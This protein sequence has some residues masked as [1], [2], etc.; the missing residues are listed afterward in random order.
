M[1]KIL[2]HTLATA[3]NEPP[4]ARHQV[5]NEL[6]KE[7]TIYFLE[8]ERLGLP[9]LERRKV[10]AN[11][12]VITPSYPVDYRVRY[13]TPGLNELF[14]KW[15]FK[16]ISELGIDFD[17]VITFDFTAPEIHEYFNDVIFYCAD[18]NVGLGKFTPQYVISYHTRMEKEV[19]EKSRL[20]IVTSEYML[21][22]IKAYNRSTYLVPLGAPEVSKAAVFREKQNAQPVLGLVGYLDLNMDY[23]LLRRLLEKFQ[24]VFIGPISAKAKKDFL[25]YPNA[26]FVGVKTGNELYSLLDSIDV[27]IAPYDVNIINKG[28]TPNKLWL[29]L[30]TGK[31]VV[32]TEVPNI[33][34]WVFEEK[35]VYKCSNEDFVENCLAAYRDN[36]AHLTQKRVEVARNNTWSKRVEKIM[37]FFETP[38][39]A[40]Q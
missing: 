4:R 21:S 27:C 31:P 13:R 3:W 8:K 19:A 38:K 36:N 1:K 17:L 15:L 7:H 5:T 39:E 6:K 28:L 16:S 26:N 33:R 12:T 25:K 2:I 18:D 34:N 9:K 32:V 37:E 24:I 40:V 11:V 20:C 29:Y 35:L 23:P 22:K 14:K 30:A 10:E